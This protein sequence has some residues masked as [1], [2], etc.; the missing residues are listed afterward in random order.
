MESSTPQE[1]S[2]CFVDACVFFVQLLTP[3]TPKQSLGMAYILTPNTPSSPH[4]GLLPGHLKQN[5]ISKE[6]E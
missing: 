4:S 2:E 1:P 3:D 5:F 6:T